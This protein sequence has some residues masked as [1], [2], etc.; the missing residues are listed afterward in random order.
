MQSCCASG[1]ECVSYARVVVLVV[2]ECCVSAHDGDVP[3]VVCVWCVLWSWCAC[4]GLCVLCLCSWCSGV[5]S[6]RCCACA[7]LVFAVLPW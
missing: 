5:F 6:G 2:R 1:V 3:V 7:V 4:G